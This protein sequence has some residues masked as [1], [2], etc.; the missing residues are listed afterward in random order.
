M[1]TYHVKLRIKK[2]NKRINKLDRQKQL[3]EQERIDA[4][5]FGFSYN[6]SGYSNNYANRPF[7]NKTYRNPNYTKGP[8]PS[9]QR[10]LNP[11]QQQ[12]TPKGQQKKV[13]RVK[14]TN[15]QD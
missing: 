2:N 15:E 8:N 7:P 1:I 10:Q 14:N 13:F 6:N 11:R 3:K 9:H 12:Y 4:E 5:T